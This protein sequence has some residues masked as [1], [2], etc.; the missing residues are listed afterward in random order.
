MLSMRTPITILAGD[1]GGTNC[2]LALIEYRD[3]SFESRFSRRYATQNESSIM[4]P[5]ERFLSEA[6]ESGHEDKIGRCCISGAGPVVDRKIQLTNASWAI[7]AA[8]IS[9]RFNIPVHLINDFTAVSYAVVLVDPDDPKEITRLP[10]TDGSDPELP[11]EGTSLV[12]GAGTGLGMGYVDRHADGS[13]HAYPSEG[14]HSEMP[15][16]D[17][18]SFAFFQWLKSSIGRIPNIE[19]AVSGQGISNIFS[20]LCSDGFD[21]SSARPYADECGVPGKV[22]GQTASSIMASPERDRPALIAAAK[23][24][25]P[26][27]A[28]AMDLF[29]RYYAGKVSSLTAILLPKAGVY[30]AGGI[31]SKNEAYLLEKNRFMRVFEDNYSAHIRAFIAQVPVMIVRNYSISLI[32]AANAAIQLGRL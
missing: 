31:S 5:L 12:I 24:L 30:L 23:D 20:F 21:P 3:G 29:T 25:D 9:D 4:A 6:R 13:C 16:W 14:G 17:E 15:S 26:R 19:L 11:A 18:L 8:E 22:L 1:I 32:G 10:H 27:C 7:D 28:L 2:N